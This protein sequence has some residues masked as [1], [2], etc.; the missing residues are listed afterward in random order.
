MD[1]KEIDTAK[2]QVQGQMAAQYLQEVMQVQLSQSLPSHPTAYLTPLP[3]PSR[4]KEDC[5][6]LPSRSSPQ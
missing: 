3:E 6:Q 5:A 4:L 1:D 2:L